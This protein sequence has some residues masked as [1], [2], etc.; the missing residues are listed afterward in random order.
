MPVQYV[1]N[2]WAGASLPARR[3]AADVNRREGYAVA[4]RVLTSVVQAGEWAY[5]NWLA[6]RTRGRAPL[7]RLLHR[8]RQRIPRAEVLQENHVL[9]R[10]AILHHHALTRRPGADE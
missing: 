9:R 3:I 7:S 10:T 4:D 6:A 8:R 1:S 2:H 5:E